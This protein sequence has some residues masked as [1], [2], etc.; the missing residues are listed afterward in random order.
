MFSMPVGLP[1][2]GVDTIRV[3]LSEM[4]R[5]VLD[6][7]TNGFLKIHLAVGSDKILAATLVAPHAGEMI[8]EI[9]LAMNAGM[10]LSA[11]ASV[12]H[13]YPT[14]SAIIKQAAD[15]YNRKRLTP[16]VQ[17]MLKFIIKIGRW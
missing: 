14:Q 11:I 9:T 17:K 10:S 1:A 6:S 8:S 12:I 7:Q 3:D 2:E 4:D 15:V 16:R 5:A 13:P